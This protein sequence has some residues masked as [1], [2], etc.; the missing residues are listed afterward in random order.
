MANKPAMALQ[1]RRNNC[2]I[3]G[4]GPAH[5]PTLNRIISRKLINN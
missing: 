3:K 4:S 5:K 1:Y 2:P